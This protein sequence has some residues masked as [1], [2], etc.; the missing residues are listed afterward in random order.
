L[1]LL[2]DFGGSNSS[3]SGGDSF[4]VYPVLVGAR[5]GS[6]LNEFSAFGGYSSTLDASPL[7]P[8]PSSCVIQ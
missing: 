4:H 5:D 3:S 2:N 7:P 8:A 1:G 6:T